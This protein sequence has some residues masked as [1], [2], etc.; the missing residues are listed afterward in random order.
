MNKRRLSVLLC[1]FALLCALAL[2]ASGSSSTPIYL[3]AAN[4]KFCDLPG[5]ALPI[6]VNGVIYV[7]YSIF[8]RNLTGVDLGVYYGI[9]LERNTILTLYS[10]SGML[11]F[12]V[13]M[14]WCE[15]NQG[16]SMNFHAITRS[17]ANIPYVPAA[18]VCAF[19]GLQYSFLPTTDRG[20]AI[21]ITNPSSPHMD[22]G[23]FLTSARGAMTTRYN[24][25][26]QSL[27][28][29]PSASPTAPVSPPPPPVASRPP[30]DSNRDVHVYLSI[31]ASQAQSD[32]T[33]LFPTGVYALFL[34]TPD[35]LPAQAALVRRAVAAGHSVGFILDD[36]PDMD[37]ALE[38]LEEGNRLLSHI[39]RVKTRIVSVDG[40][41]P[42]TLRDALSSEGWAVWSPSFRRS[43]NPST[44]QSVLGSRPSTVRMDLSAT[45]LSS[46]SRV[47]STLRDNGYD[48]R[49]PLETDL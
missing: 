13:T 5:G 21:R 38:Q 45:S 49:Q 12:N 15:D 19:F 2:P 8:D 32:L 22:D 4:D 37:T 43:A 40:G 11:T 28:P 17:G 23:T 9:T 18:A 25:I 16:N 41:A 10:L 35:S 29:Q 26:L 36:A 31:D 48:L 33:G 39:A 47:V 7:P 42:G 24:Q 3:L 34:F 1:L 14:G 46:V 30:E 27:A 20:T 6:A 44:I